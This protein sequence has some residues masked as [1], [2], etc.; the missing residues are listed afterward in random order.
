[1][2]EFINAPTRMKSMDI[3]N[4]RPFLIFIWI[5]YQSTIGKIWQKINSIGQVW[6]LKV[7]SSWFDKQTTY[8]NINLDASVNT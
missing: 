3:G 1:M 4:A 7:F 6:K 8:S 5:I 2:T